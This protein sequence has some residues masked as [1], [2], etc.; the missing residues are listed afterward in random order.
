MPSTTPSND[1]ER[2]ALLGYRQELRRD[3]GPFASF[4][5]GFSFVSVLTTVFEMFPLGYSFGGPVFFWT[6]PLVFAGQFC[7]ALC[8]AEL[9]ARFPVSGAIYQWSSRLACPEFGWVAGWLTLIGYIV[10]VSAI[11]I[12]M[13]SILP[14]LW[15]GFQLVGGNRDVTSL[16]GAENAV[17]LGS[18]T[19]LATTILSC[20]GV[21][22]SAFVTVVGVYAEIAGLCLL[23]G[24]LF[25]NARRGPSVV[26]DTT[27][28]AV[29]M[30]P[31]NAFLASMLMAVYVMYGF[32]SAAELAEETRDPARV[33]PR[34]IVRCLLLS[35]AA[36]G[37]VIIG[38]LM[39]APSLSLSDLATIGIPSVITAITSGLTGRVLLA[40]V[41]IS[42]LSA[43]IAIQTSASR[44]LFSMARDRSIPG[45][46]HLGQVSPR[47]G[48]PVAATMIIG[49]CS[50]GFLWI[51]FGDSSL[52]SAITAS[53]VSVA[54]CAYLFVTVPLLIQR[55]RWMKDRTHA[56]ISFR[57]E[58]SIRRMMVNICAV[59]F[60]AFFLLN[61][62]WPRAAVL[63]PSGTRP[64]MTAFPAAFLSAALASG[65]FLRKI[66]HF[67]QRNSEG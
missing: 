39:A 45:C 67:Q 65:L 18:V 51:N 26:F 5:A 7:V 64:Y 52:F 22:I 37:L 42:V 24:L 21:R 6:W 35:F 13:Q 43:T 32:D 38:A 34:A 28:M 1:S 44:V 11:A 55:L 19:I 60:G 29:G 48:T 25:L 40:T 54:Y 4:A 9:A 58:G 49:L 23:I 20:A 14:N 62:L 50:A 15:G 56:P 57:P 8:F 27:H 16:T 59:L 63:D 41:A 46:A 33:A 3:L 10:S 30:L 2:L 12:A 61:T 66:R 31:W 47:T 17:I 36:G 53:A